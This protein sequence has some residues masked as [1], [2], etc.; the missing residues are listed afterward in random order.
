VVSL[1]D[2]MSLINGD[3]VIDAVEMGW[4]SGLG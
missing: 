1:V 3:E 4:G 2:W